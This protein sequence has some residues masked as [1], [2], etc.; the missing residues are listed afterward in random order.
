[1]NTIFT[2]RPENN[3]EALEAFI[4]EIVGIYEKE[5]RD[6]KPAHFLNSNFNPRDL[7][8]EDKRM[9]DKAK[10][11]SI[12]RADLHAYHQSIIDPRTKNVRDDVPYS[13]YTFYAFITNEASRPIGM[14]EE[15]E[16]KNKENKGT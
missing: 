9:W 7:T 11:E 13:R 4:R 15:A 1:M 2:E 6:G 10:D 3:Q 8:F 12:T 16:E 14:R 5:K